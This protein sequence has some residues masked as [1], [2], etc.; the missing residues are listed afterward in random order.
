VSG[1]TPQVGDRVAVN[2]ETAIVLG[3][4]DD[5]AWIKWEQSNYRTT[6]LVEYLTKVPEPIVY[7]ERWINVDSDGAMQGYWTRE[8]ADRFAHRKSIAVIHL[9]ADGTLTLHPVAGES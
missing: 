6:I 4:D 1:Y 3:I 7:P 8:D 5:I 2:S 9:A